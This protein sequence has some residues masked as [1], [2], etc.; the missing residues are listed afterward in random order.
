MFSTL[1]LTSCEVIFYI[2]YVIKL[3]FLTILCAFFKIEAKQKNKNR[4]NL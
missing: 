4:Q 3:D 2:F 1:D